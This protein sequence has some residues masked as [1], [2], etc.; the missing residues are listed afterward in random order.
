MTLI[1]AA[2]VFLAIVRSN[3]FE[4]WDPAV[5]FPQLNTYFNND[6]IGDSFSRLQQTVSCK[7]IP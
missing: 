1:T 4:F 7:K 2:L 3:A 5:D 6:F